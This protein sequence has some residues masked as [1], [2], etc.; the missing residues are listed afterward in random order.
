MI[1]QR[2][3]PEVNAGSMADI[4]FLL[5]I[6]FLVTTTID[7]DKG[8]TVRLPVLPT[9]PMPPEDI[10]KRN[11]LNIL[12]N[13]NDVLMVNND[14]TELSELKILTKT[15]ITNPAEEEDKPVS[16]QK[17]TISL[18]NDDGTTYQTYLTVHNELKAVYNELWNEAAQKL[19]S[20]NYEQL[21][22]EK[23]REIKALLPFRISEAEP[24]NL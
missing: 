24:D 1:Q 6:F 15:F 22:N 2:F 19:Y 10:N 8:L 4:A 18:K 11:V 3:K 9:E 7:S 20:E 17:A 21:N 5:L 12:I 14:L 16:P 23:R 13:S